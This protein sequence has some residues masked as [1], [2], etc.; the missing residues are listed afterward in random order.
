MSADKRNKGQGPRLR[1]HTPYTRAHRPS[2]GHLAAGSWAAGPMGPR[3]DGS[4]RLGTG[5][6]RRCRNLV[7]VCEYLGRG[8]MKQHHHRRAGVIRSSLRELSLF[9]MCIG[10]TTRPLAAAGDGNASC[11][12]AS[13]VASSAT[14]AERRRCGD[15]PRPGPRVAQRSAARCEM[16]RQRH[17]HRCVMAAR[18][19]HFSSHHTRHR[20]VWGR[21]FD[22]STGR[23]TWK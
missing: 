9:A 21:S 5:Q 10:F 15:E 6:A 13:V 2:H 4:P 11:P 22:V 7:H 18:K 16:R 20:P 8:G 14:Q 3:R 1:T 12:M 19:G 23:P 17:H